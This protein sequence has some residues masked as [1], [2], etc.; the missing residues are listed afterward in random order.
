MD[1][2]LVHGYHII[3]NNQEILH[4]YVRSQV[5]EICWDA[6]SQWGIFTNA[7]FCKT[8]GDISHEMEDISIL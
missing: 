2:I 7:P 3:D 6:E 8:Q 4:E 1:L 5:R